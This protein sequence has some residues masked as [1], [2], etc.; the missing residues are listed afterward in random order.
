MLSIQL[1]IDRLCRRKNWVPFCRKHR[2]LFK[3]SSNKLMMTFNSRAECVLCF[4]ANKN[5]SE[6]VAIG[7]THNQMLPESVHS[8][9]RVQSVPP[10]RSA[11]KTTDRLSAGAQE[12]YSSLLLLFKGWKTFFSLIFE[13]WRRRPITATTLLLGNTADR[14][15]GCSDLCIPRTGCAHH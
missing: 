3:I 9:Q 7:R 8:T 11:L 10:S 2:P 6:G 12:P 15:I 1:C 14:Y 5:S 13:F 4:R